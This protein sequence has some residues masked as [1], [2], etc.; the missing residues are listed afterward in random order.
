MNIQRQPYFIL[1]IIMKERERARARERFFCI[2]FCFFSYAVLFVF[3]CTLLRLNETFRMLSQSFEHNIPHNTSTHCGKSLL[4]T[5]HVF[6]YGWKHESTRIQLETPSILLNICIEKK[7]WEKFCMALLL[8]WRIKN[9]NG[10]KIAN[11]PEE[12]KDKRTRWFKI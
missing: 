11:V 7:K 4:F 5:L 9:R 10:R 6:E 12:T 3:V 8:V 1:L 2:F